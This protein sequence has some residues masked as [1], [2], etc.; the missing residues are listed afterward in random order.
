MRFFSAAM[1]TAVAVSLLAGCSGNS[2]S[3]SSSM[4]NGIGAGALARHRVAT[5]AISKLPSA[6]FGQY[7]LHNVATSL[8]RGIATAQFLSLIHIFLAAET[9][10]KTTEAG[11]QVMG[12]YGYNM[13]FDMQRH[14]RDARAAT[15]AAGS[16]QIQ[17]NLIAA[18]MGLKVQ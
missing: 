9:Y 16:S 11:M 15:V 10:V 2:S 13:E 5:L 1:C 6:K 8:P 12:G 14:F 18:Q 4:P 3:P 7:R 17:R